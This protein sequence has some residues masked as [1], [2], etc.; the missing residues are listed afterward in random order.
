MR[1]QRTQ[2]DRSFVGNRVEIW[3]VL[4]AT[5]STKVLSEKA[6][7]PCMNSGISGARQCCPTHRGM[8]LRPPDPDSLGLRGFWGSG[9][10]QWEHAQISMHKYYKGRAKSKDGRKS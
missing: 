7:E 2:D 4:P 8:P 10:R 3:K 9:L 1:E 5:I 6:L